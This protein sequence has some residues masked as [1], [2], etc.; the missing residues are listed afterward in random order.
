MASERKSKPKETFVI[1]CAKSL[2]DL[3][4]VIKQFAGED[5]CPRVKEAECYFAA[6]LTDSFLIG[7]LNGERISCISLIKHGESVA[8]GGHYFTAEPYREHGYG[9]QLYDFAERSVSYQCNIQTLALPQIAGYN[10][11]RGYNPRWVVRVY[12]FPASR[13]VQS[14]ASS[15]MPPSIAQILPAKQAE[16]NKLFEYGADTLGTSQVC[17]NLLAAWLSHLHK[18]S[19]VAIDHAGKVVGY[20]IMSEIIRFSEEG[21]YI[22][23]LFADS[24]SIARS[25]LKVAVGFAS[26]DNP[27]STMI[28]DLPADNLEGMSILVNEIGAKLEI[29]LTVMSR[30]EI[31]NKNLNKVFSNAS[32]EVV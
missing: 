12:E 13:A 6:G 31:T 10:Q 8:V 1:R 30:Y 29:E 3:Q 24:A 25:L 18:S 11:K 9:K 16:F 14:L 7:E 27:S 15:Q 22:A 5:N 4:W 28:M 17:K 2:D 32:N 23:P 26:E 20:L 21:Y 19:W